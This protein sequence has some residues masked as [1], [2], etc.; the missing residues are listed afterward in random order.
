MRK[1]T[2]LVF[3]GTIYFY[4]SF[5]FSNEPSVALGCKGI[6]SPSLASNF[7]A[8]F[9]SPSGQKSSY[10]K[11]CTDTLGG[12]QIDPIICDKNNAYTNSKEIYSYDLRLVIDR[13]TLVAT[14][15]SNARLCNSILHARES[16]NTY[17]A[18][19]Q[20][21]VSPNAAGTLNAVQRQKEKELSLNKI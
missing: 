14:R 5:S 16:A 21:E 13:Q 10:N 11:I 19:Y 3:L 6:S 2:K 9:Y 12:T 17:C 15:W 1:A 4:S 7:Y 18:R 8:F 20:C